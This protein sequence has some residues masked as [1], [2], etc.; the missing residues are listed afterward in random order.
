M[1]LRAVLWDFAASSKLILAAWHMGETGDW[2]SEQKSDETLC[3][4]S[5]SVP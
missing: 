5:E 1:K 2:T 3:S 4:Y